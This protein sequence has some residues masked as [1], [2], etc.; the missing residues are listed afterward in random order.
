MTDIC[1]A[2]HLQNFRTMFTHIPTGSRTWEKLKAE[3]RI[4]P[5]LHEVN[6]RLT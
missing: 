6:R 4:I 5:Y 3:S 1:P 2:E